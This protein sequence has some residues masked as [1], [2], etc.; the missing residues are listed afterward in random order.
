MRYYLSG[1]RVKSDTEIPTAQW[2]HL[3][4]SWGELPPR[5]R[6]AR[7]TNWLRWRWWDLTDWLS[8]HLPFRK[9]N[10]TDQL[11][12]GYVAPVKKDW[13]GAL[14]PE[15]IARLADLSEHND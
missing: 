14:T 15:Q 11:F 4:M 3:S 9:D 13:I 10:R 7:L 1:K 6:M 8:I 12:T 5:T 2:I